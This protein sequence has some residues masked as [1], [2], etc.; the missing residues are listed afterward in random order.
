MGRSPVLATDSVTVLRPALSSISPSLMKR[1]PGIIASLL[2]DRFV[3]GDELGAVGERRLDLDV[4]DHFGNARHHLIASQHLRAGLHQVGHGAAV[5]G[6]LHDEIGDDRDRL[7]VIKF[8]AALEPAARYHGGHRDQQLVLF[9]GGKIHAG[10][11]VYWN[12]S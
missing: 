4:V 11:L 12:F 6:T 7:G 9:A 3:D 5:A 2:S 1:S 10:T 8:D